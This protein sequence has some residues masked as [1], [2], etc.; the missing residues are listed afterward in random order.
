MS[1]T[2]G[3]FNGFAVAPQVNDVLIVESGLPLRSLRNVREDVVSTMPTMSAPPGNTPAT[4]HLLW[5][6]QATPMWPGFAINTVFYAAIL[7]LLFATP[8]ALRRWR[9]IKRGLC[10]ACAYPVGA[11]DVCTECGARVTRRIVE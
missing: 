5:L 3:R 6:G 9:R 4:D 10:P 7:W 8:F 11:S 1:T 2:D